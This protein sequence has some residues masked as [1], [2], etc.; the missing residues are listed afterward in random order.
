MS[1]TFHANAVK[2]TEGPLYFVCMVQGPDNPR[3]IEYLGPVELPT[4]YEVIAWNRRAG[5][6][7]GSQHYSDPPNPD[8]ACF[9]MN[10]IDTGDILIP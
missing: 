1:R 5:W 7:E 10:T 8:P 2:I 9:G 4:E 3:K 6:D